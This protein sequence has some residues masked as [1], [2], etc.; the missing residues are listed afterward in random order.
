MRSKEP[1]RPAPRK[2][3]SDNAMERLLIYKGARKILKWAPGEITNK[4]RPFNESMHRLVSTHL[5]NER[6]VHIR[7]NST[8]PLQMGGFHLAFPEY[9]EG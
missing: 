9:A 8:I 5:R 7:K 2:V 1:A 6:H 3:V 4:G